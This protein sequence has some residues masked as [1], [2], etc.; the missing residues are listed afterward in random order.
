MVPSFTLT[1]DR[2]N[3]LPTRIPQSIDPT[4]AQRDLSLPIAEGHTGVPVRLRIEALPAH[5]DVDVVHRLPNEGQQ[6]CG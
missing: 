3:G 4:H 5:G 6:L 1:P 2:A